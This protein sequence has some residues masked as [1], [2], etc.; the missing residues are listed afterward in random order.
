VKVT[1]DTNA[2]SDWRKTGAWHKILVLAEKI[3]VPSIVIGE[4]DFGFRQGDRYQENWQKLQ[5]FL[6]QA[7]VE[8]WAI[9]S[10]EARIYGGLIQNLKRRG[11]PIPSNDCW[12]AACSEAAGSVLLTHDAHFTQLPQL[13]LRVAEK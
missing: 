13:Q 11:T 2:Y 10:R 8:E 1:L 5:D 6:N 7:Q 4:L 12:I 9:G 3:Y